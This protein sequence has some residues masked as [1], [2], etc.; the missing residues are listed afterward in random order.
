MSNPEQEVGKNRPGTDEEIPPVER[1]GE[2]ATPDPLDQYRYTGS[3]ENEVARTGGEPAE[4]AA[5][6]TEAQQKLSPIVTNL[7]EGRDKMKALHDMVKQGFGP[8]TPQY[9]ANFKIARDAYLGAIN[10]ASTMLYD[11][12]AEGR[13]T[14]NKFYKD[15][16][17]ERALL[18]KDMQALK[19]TNPAEYQ[20]L[21]Q[22][23]AMLGDV[24]RANGYAHANYGL[25]LLRTSVYLPKEQRDRQAADGN[26][27]LMLASRYDKWMMGDPPNV[28]PDP[29]FMKH[30]E[31]IMKVVNGTPYRDG[32]GNPSPE[33]PRPPDVVPGTNTGSTAELPQGYTRTAVGQQTFI[34]GNKIRVP[35]GNVVLKGDGSADP[36]DPLVA[37]NGNPPDFEKAIQ[38]ADALDKVPLI[39][40]IE[41]LKKD[42][43]ASQADLTTKLNTAKGDAQNPL[44]RYALET[45]KL[46]NEQRALSDQIATL[47]RTGLPTPPA[48]MTP[49]QQKQQQALGWMWDNVQTTQ[50]LTELLGTADPQLKPIADA[51]KTHPKF[52]EINSAFG[53][54][55]NKK[56]QLAALDEGL[57]NNPA[58]KPFWDQKQALIAGSQQLNYLTALYLS[59]ITAR[60]MRVNQLQA[61]PEVA[62]TLT[63]ADKAKFK[64]DPEVKAVRQRVNEL[65]NW[66]AEPPAGL[67]NLQ[68]ALGDASATSQ[69]VPPAN[70]SEV[71]P[72]VAPNSEV[73]RTNDNAEIPPELLAKVAPLSNVEKAFTGSATAFGEVSA[74]TR[75]ATEVK[76]LREFD[77]QVKALPQAE[78]TPA[79]IAEI[80]TKVM[81]ADEFMSVMYSPKEKPNLSAEIPQSI[82][83]SQARNFGTSQYLAQKYSLQAKPN[84]A[85][86]VKLS[87]DGK[88][89]AEIPKDV[90]DFFDQA[91]KVLADNNPQAIQEMVDAQRQIYQLRLDKMVPKDQ[92][93]GLKTQLNGLQTEF[94]KAMAALKPE[95]KGPLA[96]TYAELQNTKGQIGGKYLQAIPAF[97]SELQQVINGTQP[98]SPQRMQMLQQLQGKYMGQVEANPEYKKEIATAEE[99]AWAQ[100]K[101]MDSGVDAVLVAQK[102]L[103]NFVAGVDPNNPN[104]TAQDRAQ[105]AE[106]I[107]AVDGFMTASK[108][109]DALAHGTAVVQSYQARALLFSSNPA[110]HA[111]ALELMTASE[112]DPGAAQYLALPQNEMQAARYMIAAAGQVM[113]GSAP[114]ELFGSML[115]GTGAPARGL[116][117]LSNG[118]IMGSRLENQ[119]AATLAL[120]EGYKYD[121]VF[122]QAQIAAATA[123]GNKAG[124]GMFRDGGSILAYGGTYLGLNQLPK[125]GLKALPG[126]LKIVAAVGAAG[127]TSD[128]LEDGTLQGPW[129]DPGAY[130]RGG[131]M[132]L[133][134]HGAYKTLLGNWSHTAL[135]NSAT[136]RIAETGALNAVK[137]ETGMMARW[138]SSIKTGTGAYLNPK[139]FIGRNPLVT[140]ETIAGAEGA[141]LLALNTQIGAMSY[142]RT[143]QT[144]FAIGA[145]SEG[146]KI[147]D[148]QTP[149][150]GLNDALS[151]MAGSGGMA[152]LT[153]GVLVPT[154][155]MIPRWGLGKV[156]GVN[157]L[158]SSN[159]A[160]AIYAIGRT[161]AADFSSASS[162]YSMAKD[163][164]VAS[165]AAQNPDQLYK[166]LQSANPGMSETEARVRAKMVVQMQKGQTFR[167][168]QPG[169]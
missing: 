33:V 42:L 78:R 15:I 99:T 152:A 115:P 110:D 51:L 162:A 125:L 139:N 145:T 31:A 153:S 29:N 34:D 161:Y 134:A 136:A 13:L 104:Q 21:A 64:D 11:T 147:V 106:K 19:T 86:E 156:P 167:R 158:L 71:A 149:V 52:A 40:N 80:Q 164:E 44:N 77:K 105:R 18:Q 101:S 32:G 91:N 62:Q 53:Q 160:G 76:L 66:Q 36:N 118:Y 128:Y 141:Q 3:P 92:Q 90:R 127:V 38:L 2:T 85:D 59:P 63:G 111:K 75:F 121:P 120:A 70:N 69:V 68:K 155:V 73:A 135:S 30:R 20:R 108:D 87:E 35:S 72:P 49:E 39:T 97:Q 37:M 157:T 57:K 55:L 114:I 126:P 79:K 130:L 166:V 146:L 41:K 65:V 168:Q 28:P 4:R 45:E 9:D 107:A 96:Q 74:L 129:N 112:G 169:G 67:T 131:G 117:H 84:L 56:V 123:E 122:T 27:E 81:A 50:Q 98:N 137:A 26:S 12:D 144:A 132:G 58:T 109:L 14:P 142:Y 25:A 88:H 150:A 119:N 48:Q 8:G 151:K 102:N 47:G 165:A 22:E 60:E 10:K 143:V 138:M 1:T 93:E 61:D 124:N 116:A 163:L 17:A 43:A 103:D 6:R 140:A 23:D 54:F 83:E 82:Q 89:L 16:E 100:L 7:E 113:Q 95:L 148:G 24:L 94:D 5:F 154:A 133:G 159:T 46:T